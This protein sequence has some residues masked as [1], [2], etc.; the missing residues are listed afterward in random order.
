MR[1]DQYRSKSLHYFNSFAAQ[2][3]IPLSALNT[4]STSSLNTHVHV[5]DL[6]LPSLTDDKAFE[7]GLN[8]IVSR[9]ITSYMPFFTTSFSDLVDWHIDHKY[10]KEMCKMS[11]VVSIIMTHAHTIMMDPCIVYIIIMYCYLVYRF[12]LG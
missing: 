4:A 3:R 5:S 2:D 9:I 1:Y 11:T 12:L 8:I 6:I 10:S 7:N